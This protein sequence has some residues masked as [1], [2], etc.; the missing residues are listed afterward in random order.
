MLN[1]ASARVILRNCA[2]SESEC[3]AGALAK[4]TSR[5]CKKLPSPNT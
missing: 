3:V 5:E 1:I 4:A 2:A